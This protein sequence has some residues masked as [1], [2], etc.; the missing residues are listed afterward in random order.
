MLPCS[1]KRMRDG[2]ARERAE[3]GERTREEGGR[4]GKLEAYF[5]FFGVFCCCFVLFFLHSP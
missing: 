4:M 5:I 2:G 1:P 3:R